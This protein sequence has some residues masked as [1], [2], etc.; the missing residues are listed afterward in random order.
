MRT[1]LSITLFLMA[2]SSHAQRIVYAE[3]EV[4]YE[5]IANYTIIGKVGN[6]Y[7]IHIAGPDGSEIAAYDDS[8]HKVSRGSLAQLQP[9]LNKIEFFAY[10][11]KF[12]LASQY[13][14]NGHAYLNIHV[15]DA[16]G[17]IAEEP[18]F[19]DS[20]PLPF[21]ELPSTPGIQD[22]YDRPSYVVIRS[23]DRQWIMA[24]YIKLFPDK[25]YVL[26]TILLDKNLKMLERHDM[27][28]H[29]LES[30]GNATEFIL[31]NDGDLAFAQ[32]GQMDEESSV[33]Q[34]L[35]FR[36]A[37][38]EDSLMVRLISFGANGLDDPR[39]KADNF[40]RKYLITAM[41]RKPGSKN[42]I[43]LFGMTWDKQKGELSS[44]AFNPIP[45]QTR[46]EARNDLSSPDEIMNHFY[47]RQVFPRRDGGSIV[48]AEMCYGAERYFPDQWRRLDFIAGPPAS[49]LVPPRQFLFYK[50][51]E[52]QGRWQNMTR[53]PV[54][55]APLSFN[56]NKYTEDILVMF[57]DKDANLTGQRVIK[58]AEFTSLANLPL[59]YQTMVDSKSI[60]ILYNVLVR[61][62]YLPYSTSIKGDGSITNDQ[63]PYGLD[64]KHVFLP[65]FA[66]QVGPN[67][68]IIPAHYKNY[69]R[70]ALLEF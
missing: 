37:R 69:L 55:R 23:E 62:K 68:A 54:I 40:T 39:L 47:L 3:P 45:Q 44:A 34:L 70:F 17:K 29:L 48:L 25:G 14:Q 16:D 4:G 5:N 51:R 30:G 21:R 26:G 2:F 43:G 67:L 13:Q 28:L 1:I 52:K 36:K 59:S 64:N 15:G 12:Y 63:L 53:M 46:L 6:H 19:A 38:G 66:K 7:L 18:A 31:D 9:S 10:P 56:A 32:Q 27:P 50:P 60:H 8:M 22:D 24:L 20:M 49:I 11:D 61:G 58:K 35:F 57:L 42:V 33:H 65:Q 41:Y